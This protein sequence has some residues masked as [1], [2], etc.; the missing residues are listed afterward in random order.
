MYNAENS[1]IREGTETATSIGVWT[2]NYN[3]SDF[4]YCR[5]ELESNGEF[6]LRRRRA[7]NEIRFSY[8]DNSWGSGNQSHHSQAVKWAED[9]LTAEEYESTFGE[10]II[11]EDEEKGGNIYDST[12]EIKGTEKINRRGGES[13]GNNK[14]INWFIKY[15]KIM[16]GLQIGIKAPI[17][18][19]YLRV[20]LQKLGIVLGYVK[21]VMEN[22]TKN[23]RVQKQL[24]EWL[25]TAH[26]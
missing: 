16:S 18:R 10:H 21:Q 9:N 11:D 22:R 1:L 24:S 4:G 19:V 20:S 12:R 2:N 14:G 3:P 8:G 17:A 13:C 26:N 6:F 23:R 7:S 15:G 5:E 25:N